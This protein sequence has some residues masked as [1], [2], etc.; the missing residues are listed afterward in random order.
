M[1]ILEKLVL[2]STMFGLVFTYGA[3][4]KQRR[5][6]ETLQDQFYDLVQRFNRHV[7][8]DY[9]IEN[10]IKD[11]K[12]KQEKPTSVEETEKPDEQR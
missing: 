12:K 5:R 9:I 7:A 3:V 8:R 6:F 11:L 2:L 4:V 1:T 10:D